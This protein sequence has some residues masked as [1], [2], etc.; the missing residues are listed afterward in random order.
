MDLDRTVIFTGA[1]VRPIDDARDK[2][3]PEAQ[4]LFSFCMPA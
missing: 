4:Y 1:P 2:K 3:N